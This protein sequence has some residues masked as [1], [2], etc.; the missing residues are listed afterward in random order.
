MAHSV[1]LYAILG[2]SK[3]AEDVVIKAAWRALAQRY[4]PDKFESSPEIAK[5]KM[6]DINMAYT[7]L[8][9]RELR[10][11]YD[12]RSANNRSEDQH[13][14]SPTGSEPPNSNSQNESQNADG[15]SF[16]PFRR[17]FASW[18]DVT[19]YFAIFIAFLSFLSDAQTKISD[20]AVFLWFVVAL[21]VFDAFFIALFGTTLGKW[22]LGLRLAGIDSPY[23]GVVRTLKRTLYKAPFLII[24]LLIVI[25]AIGYFK[26]RSTAWDDAAET[27]V[28]YRKNGILKDSFAVILVIFCLAANRIIIKTIE[29]GQSTQNQTAQYKPTPA[30]QKQPAPEVFV[31]PIQATQQNKEQQDLLMVA[32]EIIAT[33]PQLDVNSPT[34]NQ[35][36][37]D[38]VVRV[39]DGYVAKGH[40]IDVALRMAANDYAEVLRGQEQQKYIQEFAKPTVAKSKPSLT[41]HEKQELRRKCNIQPVMTDAEIDACR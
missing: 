41:W 14:D 15:L 24:P 6:S 18:I 13:Q 34:K 37:I 2:V 12:S 17:M 36:A 22:M 16:T 9:D 40:K 23:V 11:E 26:R 21:C 20:F 32:Q 35:L 28:S 27:I 33:F 19:I 39:R 8:S 3:D 29:V 10:A 38:Y 4:H 1:D 30:T 25:P 31:D 5:K 7:V